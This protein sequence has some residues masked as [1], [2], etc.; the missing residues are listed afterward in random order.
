[1]TKKQHEG[2][3]ARNIRFSYPNSDFTIHDMT[4]EMNPGETVCIVGESGSGKSTLARLFTGLLPIHS[5]TMFL[6][7]RRLSTH[8][9]KEREYLRRNIQMVFQ[10]PDLSLPHHLPV[11]VPLHD[12]ARLRYASRTQ[13]HKAIESIL[14][15]C[16]LPPN[17]WRRKPR[18]LSGG[19]RQRIA[20]SR[21]V[22]VEPRVLI[23]DEPTSAL[24]ASV[25][26]EIISLLHSL[27]RQLN[28]MQ[29]LIT[30]DM[31]LALAFGHH[32]CVMHEGNIVERGTP[33]TLLSQAKHDATIR[34]LN[35]IPSGD[36]TE[37]RLIA[38][39]GILR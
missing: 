32:I 39:D 20:I 14:A 12:A 31:E 7:A 29:I 26:Y 19:Q 27:R 6:G 5:G 8:T 25:Q 22:L 18:E 10:D 35:A 24:D 9:A 33:A 37:R 4:L 38:S 34:L 23:L 21:A 28:M 16:Q 15:A 13:R 3:S 1:M 11:H 2:F 36:P 30:H 17:A